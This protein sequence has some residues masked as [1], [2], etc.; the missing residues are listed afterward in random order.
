V[1][2]TTTDAVAAG[3]SI[4]V[5][6]MRKTNGC[7]LAHVQDSGGN[8]YEI[9][10]TT[11]TGL[12]GGIAVATAKTALPVGSTITVTFTVT[13]N[14]DPKY[15]AAYKTS[16]AVVI[17]Q[18][19]LATGAATTAWSSGATGTTSHAN[20]LVFTMAATNTSPV[21]S[22]PDG[23]QIELYDN[24]TTGAAFVAQYELISSIGTPS[25]SGVWSTSATN[26]LAVCVTLR[27]ASTGITRETVGTPTAV[28]TFGQGGQGLTSTITTTGAIPSGATAFLVVGSSVVGA[29]V[30]SVKDNDGNL[31]H[32]VANQTSANS[33]NASIFAR[34]M[35]AGLASG[36]I[37]TITYASG[38]SKTAQAVIGYMTGRALVDAVASAGGGS[39][40]AWSTGASGATVLSDEQSVAV[41]N[42]SSATS[43][44]NTTGSSPAMTEMNDISGNSRATVLTRASSSIGSG[45][46]V[47]AAG[48]WAAGS[49]WNA[50][51]ATFA[52]VLDGVE[53][54]TNFNVI[55]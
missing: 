47:T 54:F 25:G 22:T 36:K 45:T 14:T 21:S 10:G 40:T 19:A 49:T 1:I 38:S 53:P 24:S 34:Y 12:A 5:A 52:G 35:R 29:G 31:W 17:D 27:D 28:T 39:G 20:E 2:I 30:L 50:A 18:R 11:T 26:W 44:S 33:V 46:A 32:R 23:S 55:G 8:I 51:V 43:N 48:T 3:E 13:A 4:I 6:A 42:A 15:A 16:T 7:D 37:I 9:E 41:A